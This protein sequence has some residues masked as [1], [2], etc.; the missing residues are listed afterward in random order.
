MKNPYIV[1]SILLIYLVGMSVYA[2]PERNQ[3]V[4]YPQYWLT[5]G[6]TL[7]CIIVLAVLQRKRYLMRKK[8]S[9]KKDSRNG[10]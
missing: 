2:W 7:V 6:I 1:P 8:Q 3:A 9:E 4:S 10:N 5:I